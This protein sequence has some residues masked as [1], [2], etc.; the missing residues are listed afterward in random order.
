MKKQLFIIGFAMMLLMVLSGTV[1]AVT[2]TQVILT[3]TSSA[4]FSGQINATVEVNGSMYACSTAG[5]QVVFANVSQV[6]INYTRTTPSGGS[7][8]GACISRSNLYNGTATNWSCLFNTTILEDT[9][10]YTFTAYIYN[11]SGANLVQ[12]NTTTSTSVTIDNT[13]PVVSFDQ[14]LSTRFGDGDALTATV[15]NTSLCNIRFGSNSLLNMT[16]STG[17]TS[18]SY[19]LSSLIPDGSYDTAITVSDS[20]NSTVVT[21][22][23]VVGISQG[24]NPAVK[25]QQLAAQAAV[26]AAAA[27][28]GN[29]SALIIFLLLGAFVLFGMKSGKK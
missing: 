4:R 20:F 29:N 21:R 10:T 26:Q 1:L 9:G 22:S 6:G 11:G 12:K 2:N 17:R 8:T 28:Q 27:E 25:R 14:S 24:S 19:S 5:C 23:Y 18:C 3:P 7:E 13:V 16:L 15:T